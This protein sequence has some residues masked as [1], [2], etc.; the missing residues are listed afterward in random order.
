L[1]A[2]TNFGK[3]AYAYLHERGITDKTIADFSLGAA[4]PS[5]HSLLLICRN[6]VA[7]VKELAKAGLIRE[8]E[9]RYIMIYF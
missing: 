9:S 6:M 7:T 3:K 8:R 4:L 1:F 2:K 5:Y